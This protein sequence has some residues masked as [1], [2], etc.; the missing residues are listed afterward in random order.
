[1]LTRNLLKFVAVILLVA[2]ILKLTGAKVTPM[3]EES[4]HLPRGLTSLAIS[5]ELFL[6]IWLLSGLQRAGS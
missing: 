5:W 6:G 3:A 1:M 2:A 4:P